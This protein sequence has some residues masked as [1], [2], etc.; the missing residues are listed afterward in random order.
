MRRRIVGF[1]Q[2]DQGDWVTDL[3]CG[4]KQHMRHQ[5]PWTTRQW[6]I[7]QEGRDA[8]LG[9]ELSCAEC[10]ASPEGHR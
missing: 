6:V 1:H 5:P 7:T 9:R 3:E 2:D 4:H 10:P 8:F